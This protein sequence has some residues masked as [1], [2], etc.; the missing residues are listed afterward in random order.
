MCLARGAADLPLVGTGAVLGRLFVG[1]GL[2]RNKVEISICLTA[3]R[4][5]GQ[6]PCD[7]RVLID[8]PFTKG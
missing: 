8:L 3:K 2:G 5:P 6:K 7:G 4:Q 1:F